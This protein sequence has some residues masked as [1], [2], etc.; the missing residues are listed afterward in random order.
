MQKEIVAL[1]AEMVERSVVATDI[2][3]PSSFVIGSP[4]ANYDGDGFQEYIN[5]LFT[6]KNAFSKAVHA[7]T[8]KKTIDS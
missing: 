7:K 5:L 1:S 8:L 4:F 2:L 6:R 3:A